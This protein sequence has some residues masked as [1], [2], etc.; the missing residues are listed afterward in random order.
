MPSRP[1]RTVK[2]SSSLVSVGLQKGISEGYALLPE[3]GIQAAESCSL[4]WP[5]SAVALA[6]ALCCWVKATVVNANS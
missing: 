3:H 6:T 4:Y 5:Q 1:R 2:R